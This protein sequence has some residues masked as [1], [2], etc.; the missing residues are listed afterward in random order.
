MKIKPIRITPGM[1]EKR[2]KQVLE[3]GRPF[4]IGEPYP[5]APKR[6]RRQHAVPLVTVR[7]MRQ[8]SNKK[9]N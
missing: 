6:Y 3:S 7:Q 1:S 5:R 2:I 4:V 9:R 8:R